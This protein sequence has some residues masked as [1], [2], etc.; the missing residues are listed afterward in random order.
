M[1]TKL[2][3]LHF[4]H[5]KIRES[6]Q[7]MFRQSIVSWIFPF[8]CLIIFG[9]RLFAQTPEKLIKEA[10]TLFDAENYIEA[11]P[12]YLQLLS[13]EPR[14]STYNYRYGACLLFNSEKKPDALK[15]L[16]FAVSVPDVD[17][18]A[19][20]FLARAYHVNYYFDKAI[21]SY[22]TY[23]GLV[24]DK[25]SIKLD[26]ER[27]IEMC[28]NGQSLL[29]KVSDI[30]VKER[31]TATFSDFFRVY[32]LKDIGGSIVI[33]ELFQ[34]KIDRKKNHRAI[35]HIDDEKN[36]VFYSSYGDVDENQ[37][38]V[39]YRLK[40]EKGIWSDPVKLPNNV[41]TSFDEDFPYLD[42]N[43]KFL[44]FSSKGHNSMGGYDI[45]RV[46]IELDQMKFG[47]IEN[48]DFAI[49][50]ADDDVFYVVDKE[51]KHAYF[52]SSRQSE[53]G[54][55]HVY[56]VLVNK[57]ENTMILLAGDFV[58]T[59][60]PQG[61]NITVQIKETSTGKIIDQVKS[62]PVNG[63][64]SFSL[65]RAGKYEFIIQTEKTKTPQV[66]PYIAPQFEDS[67]LVKLNFLEEAS[68]NGVSL[69]VNQDDYYQYKEEEKNDVLANLFLAKSELQP[70]VQLLDL[71]EQTSDVNES[72]ETT[73]ILKR[74]NLDKYST[75]DLIT[76][77][78]QDLNRLKENF[79]KSEEQKKVFM[80][81]A[82]D[83]I[84]KAQQ[85][86]SSME[87]LFD[88]ATDVGLSEKEIIELRNLDKSRSQYLSS[89]IIANR[90][91]TNLQQNSNYVQG[92]IAK[93]DAVNI[94]MQAINNKQ[95][96]TLLNNLSDSEKTFVKENFNKIKDSEV[97]KLLGLQDSENRLE[98]IG[99]KLDDL[100][101]V[102]EELIEN[103]KELNDLKAKLPE[104]K[105]KEKPEIQKRIDELEV[106][107]EELQRQER[108]ISRQHDKLLVERDSI[109]AIQ[110]VYAQSRSLNPSSISASNNQRLIEARLKTENAKKI[111]QK[112]SN[113]LETVK[114]LETP[115]DSMALSSSSSSNTN[116]SNKVEQDIKMYQEEIQT[117][118]SQLQN[119]DANYEL[120]PTNEFGKLLALQQEKQNKIQKQLVAITNLSKL[121]NQPDSMKNEIESYQTQLAVTENII[122]ELNEKILLS[123]SAE[124]SKDLEKKQLTDQIASNKTQIQSLQTRIIKADTSDY[125]GAIK[126]ERGLLNLQNNQIESMQALMLMD[127]D[128]QV[129]KNDY[130]KLNTEKIDTEIKIKNLELKSNL[131]ASNGGINNSENANLVVN[132][133]SSNLKLEQDI[134]NLRSS[135]QL[136]T[137][138]LALDYNN[139]ENVLRVQRYATGLQ[140]ML[141]DSM[142]RS[143]QKQTIQAELTKAN[144]WLDK[145]SVAK[146]NNLNSENQQV[147]LDTLAVNRSILSANSV[148]VITENNEKASVLVSEIK[149][150]KLEND[151]LLTLLE[152]TE[153]PKQD[154]R[155]VRR[156]NKNDKKIT[157]N[158]IVLMVVEENDYAQVT[159]KILETLTP[160]Q[161][162]DPRFKSEFFILSQRLDEVQEAIDALRVASPSNQERVMVQVMNLREDFIQ[163][164]NLLNTQIAE[165]NEIDRTVASTRIE[166]SLLSDA[167]KLDYALV[168]VIEEIE[169]TETKIESLQNNLSSYTKSEQPR[170]ENDIADLKVH[171]EEMTEIRRETQSKL[172]QRQKETPKN[173]KP[174]SLSNGAIDEQLL[175]QLSEDNLALII[176]DP[177]FISLRN[178]LVTFRLLEMRML[179]NTS[180]VNSAKNEMRAL[181]NKIVAEPDG[182]IKNELRQRLDKIAV[183]YLNTTNEA[184]TSDSE[185]RRLKGKIE[186][187]K[188]YTGNPVLFNTLAKSSKIQERLVALTSSNV[189]PNSPAAQSPGITFVETNNAESQNF[190]LNP[191]SVPGMIYKIQIGA[192]NKPIDISQFAEFNPITTDQV[193]NSIRYSAGLF[194]NKNQAF[195]SL[196]PIKALGYKDAFVVAYCD[197]VRYAVAEADELLRQGKCAL[198]NA[199]EMAFESKAQVQKS[200]TYNLAPN[201]A[202]ALA[203]EDAKGLLFTVQIGVYNTPRSSA[204]MQ[205]LEPL[206]TQLT[207]RNQLR[208]SL[209]RF[210]NV[211]DAI[212]QRDQV[213]VKGFPDAFV[214]AYFNGARVSISEA[215]AILNEQGDMALYN[216]QIKQLSKLS[217]LVAITPLVDLRDSVQSLNKEAV[218]FRFV[219]LKVYTKPPQSL[220]EDQRKSNLWVYYDENLGR[221]VSSETNQKPADA[222][223]GYEIQSILKG[224]KLKDTTLITM[225]SLEGYKTDEIYYDLVMSWDKN[226]P[227]MIA[228]ELNENFS[229]AVSSWNPTERCVKFAPLNYTQ[230]EKIRKVLGSYGFVSFAENVI[231]F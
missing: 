188:M 132:S 176:Q 106:K 9:Q 73:E 161:K 77:S 113:I 206:N 67:R 59:A 16:K 55:I 69:K 88:K 61:K 78:N 53:G 174:L 3:L 182:A 70:N 181:V 47:T 32:N 154:K 121:T 26:L 166:A 146:A 201:A 33:T 82:S 230:K 224:F 214:V 115:K 225:E 116:T 221:L 28:R 12:K 157:N 40:N 23:K 45:F 133:E 63:A 141:Q 42:P 44:Y 24:K 62:N 89:A 120:I 199:A 179:N 135:N 210:D 37:K 52:A 125:S 76:I 170:I 51:Y 87:R 48:L 183:D 99:I 219:S 21:R 163:Q 177:D 220:I 218:T 4:V 228:F 65:P 41:N 71:L 84:E 36:V 60:N 202:P 172:Q 6:N 86:E 149:T 94:K 222:I 83:N 56:R 191:I 175:A 110:A 152:S 159:E 29:N 95:D 122:T 131:A 108:F 180:K 216:K 189:T 72:S 100:K 173:T 193:G 164:M 203:V 79:K 208:Y 91:A 123:S 211:Q 27:Q 226:L 128:N 2:K 142:W 153:S 107:F 145:V 160:E 92:D 11:T 57:F 31:S 215:Q 104:A 66:I 168:N 231:T 109:K 213:K 10:Q 8:V 25:T 39:Y 80:Q 35:V 137:V 93:A 143:S 30:I 139:S 140:S 43:G 184:T 169:A 162:N 14:N 50:S 111:N 118:L 171:L 223:D 124:T 102:K 129:L 119:L 49:S 97:S 158:Q 17:P 136:D 15:Y 13:L 126:L 138:L 75:E 68:G 144:D 195:T 74:L 114:I 7:D 155:I 58:S 227:A 112:T 81:L 229:F 192:F 46:P 96:V 117:T 147:P 130:E 5:H 151:S 196:N 98:Q 38:D 217:E 148:Q 150:L 1:E 198:N 22:L 207:E 205:N 103:E 101:E 190:S 178:D 18:E 194:Y 64:I 54:K 200:S 197:G 187:N 34:S 85:V 105:K 19:H 20:Y 209:G 212:V 204:L 90:F 156:I 167:K 134:Y 185:L 165:Q 186:S 127:A